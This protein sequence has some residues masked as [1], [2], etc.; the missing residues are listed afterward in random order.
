MTTAAETIEKMTD[1]GAAIVKPL[2]LLNDESPTDHD[3]HQ[4]QPF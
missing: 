1:D 3:P 2:E 4:N